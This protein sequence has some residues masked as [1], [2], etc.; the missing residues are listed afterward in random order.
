MF[1]DEHVFIIVKATELTDASYKECLCYCNCA[2][3]YNWLNDAVP[4]SVNLHHISLSMIITVFICLCRVTVS[5]LKELRLSMMISPSVQTFIWRMAWSSKCDR[6]LLNISNKLLCFIM[7][8]HWYIAPIKI[9]HLS[10]RFIQKLKRL[11][12]TTFHIDT[13]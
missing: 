2:Q 1:Y 11:L 8:M 3:I 10:C 4:G 13:G 9:L 5:C 6:L 7:I 12:V